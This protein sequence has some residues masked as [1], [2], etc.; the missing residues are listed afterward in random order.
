MISG[1]VIAIADPAVTGKPIISVTVSNAS[2]EQ[3]SIPSQ[4]AVDTG[5]TGFLTLRPEAITQPGLPFIANQP[6][7]L[8]D[9]AIGHYD[10]YAGRIVWHDQQRLIPIFSVDSDPLVGMALLWNSRLTMD[11][12]PDGRV[13][14]TPLPS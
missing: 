4:A 9:G 13:T 6:A 11:I 1:S 5:F 3:L 14:I 10:V 8:A 2:D 12:V 7:E